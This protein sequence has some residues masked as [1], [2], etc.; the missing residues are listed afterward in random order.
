MKIKKLSDIFIIRRYE[1]NGLQ[2][3]RGVSLSGV[4]AYENSSFDLAGKFLRKGRHCFICLRRIKIN[5]VV[6]FR[7]FIKLV[8]NNIPDGIMY[9]ETGKEQGG[10]AA[11]SQKHHEKA[12]FIPKDIPQGY[13]PEEGKVP[14]EEMDP[15]KE[16]PFPGFRRFRPHK[17]C[18]HG[19]KL[20]PADDK[21]YTC[22]AQKGR[23]SGYGGK[24]GV[25]HKDNAGKTVKY[26]VC[27]PDGI[28]EQPCPEEIA[29]DCADECG[30]ARVGNILPQYGTVGIA[31]GLQRADLS[32]LLADHSGHGGHAD[33]SRHQ[34]KEDRE[35]PGNAFNHL[36]ITFQT[37]I[38]YIICPGEDIGLRL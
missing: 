2:A 23:G 35:D 30:R 33:K 22:G 21:C 38:S 32:A 37:G 5:G 36:G 13:L 4:L 11:D 12:L 29:G 19:G 6:I 15:F 34:E 20:P 17:L 9:A 10:A 16:D 24:A 26:A 1:I 7:Y 18:R 31:K 27:C 25:K 8:F 14:P 28:G 3:G